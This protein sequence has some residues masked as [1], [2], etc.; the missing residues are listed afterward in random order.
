MLCSDEKKGNMSVFML[1]LFGGVILL[2]YTLM[3]GIDNSWW[4]R[5]LK[6]RI[7][8]VADLLTALALI[9]LAFFHKQIAAQAF[10]FALTLS[11]LVWTHLTR[12]LEYI[13]RIPGRFCRTVWQFLFNLLYLIFAIFI[14]FSFQF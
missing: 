6:N 13:F 5:E 14:L 2:A 1:L 12:L 7:L 8:L 9:I 3:R 10:V 11:F 4:S